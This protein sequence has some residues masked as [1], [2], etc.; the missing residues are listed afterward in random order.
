MKKRLLTVIT[1]IL[2]L[3]LL[4]ACSQTQEQEAADT[5]AVQESENDTTAAASEDSTENSEGENSEGGDTEAEY[6][7][8]VNMGSIDQSYYAF[9]RMGMENV[10]QDDVELYV[11]YHE[12]DLTTQIKQIEDFVTMGCDL[13]VVVAAD[14]DGILP[15]LTVAKDAGIPVIEMDC[16]TNYFPE[17]SIGLFVSDDYD[18][19]YQCGIAMA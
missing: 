6:L 7:V 3:A 4:S 11:T 5:E 16:P 15:A 9:L 14:P 8:G 17:Y 1:A 18:A 12:W 2:L 13:I 19:G 10:R